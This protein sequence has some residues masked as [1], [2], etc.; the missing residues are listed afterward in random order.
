[1]A[2]HPNVQ[3]IRDAYA[4]FVAGDLTA[5]L[6]DVAPNG[7]FHFNGEG[8]NSGDH[9]GAEAI[10]AALINLFELTGGTQVLDIKGVF[11]D[12]RH[13]VVVLRE[14]ATRTDGAK[15]DVNES[16]VLAFDHEGRI[17]DLWDLPDDP[18]AHD[19]FFD[20]RSAARRLEARDARR[21]PRP[22]ALEALRQAS[23]DELGGHGGV[24][25]VGAFDLL[26][27]VLRPARVRGQLLL[28]GLQRLDVLVTGDP[29]DPAV[30]AGHV[31]E[32][33]LTNT[34]ICGN[35]LGTQERP[36]R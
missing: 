36:V 9:K 12:D 15:L 2:E 34:D 33:G 20:G 1:M 8:P 32:H 35:Y 22:Q 13:G 14:T 31:G 11:A 25:G 27:E 24:I 28:G 19:R 29:T 23:I 10:S 30:G 17:T 5:A 6:K 3:R 7:V 4:A 21:S 16:H 18:E 26:V